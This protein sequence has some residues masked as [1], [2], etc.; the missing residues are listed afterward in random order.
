[1][2][3]PKPIDEYQSLDWRR[4]GRGAGRGYGK[5]KSYLTRDGSRCGSTPS[6]EARAFRSTSWLA[7]GMR[8]DSVSA[9]VPSAVPPGRRHPVLG[10]SGERLLNASPVTVGRAGDCLTPDHAR[11]EFEPGFWLRRRRCDDADG[12]R[13]EEGQALIEALWAPSGRRGGRLQSRSA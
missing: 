10:A 9:D 4:T 3:D 12:G 11:T 13:G 2:T 6:R 7:S 8:A 1:V 5:I